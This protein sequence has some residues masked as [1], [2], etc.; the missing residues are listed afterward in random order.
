MHEYSIVQALLE[1]VREQADAHGASAVHRLRV[2]VGELS[3]VEIE[4]LQSA[5]EL[6]RERSICDGAALEVVPVA[7]RW[8]CPDC[9]RTIARGEVLRCAVCALPARLVEG[10]EIVL[11]RVELEVA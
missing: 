4:L 1:R 5:Y 9:G 3:G 8:V 2:R 11:E 6:F 10:D 7:A